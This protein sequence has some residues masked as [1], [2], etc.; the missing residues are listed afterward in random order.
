MFE[1]APA[2]VVW[3][4]ENKE[5]ASPDLNVATEGRPLFKGT[6]ALT[7]L[8]LDIDLASAFVYLEANLS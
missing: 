2:I 8:A 7:C 4:V 3:F 5:T 1:Q 6:A